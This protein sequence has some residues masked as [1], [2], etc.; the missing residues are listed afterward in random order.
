M[1]FIAVIT[2]L[3]ISLAGGAVLSILQ[4]FAGTV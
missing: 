2:F 4:G 3:L 1:N